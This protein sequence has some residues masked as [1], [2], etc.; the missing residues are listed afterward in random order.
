MSPMFT[1]QSSTFCHMCT[2]ELVASM[3]II[4]AA[5]CTFCFQYSRPRPQAGLSQ[6]CVRPVVSVCTVVITTVSSKLYILV[7]IAN[8]KYL[9]QRTVQPLMPMPNSQSCFWCLAKSGKKKSIPVLTRAC[10]WS[11]CTYKPSQNLHCKM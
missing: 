3:C 4:M 8:Q 1:Y 7:S 10:F 6:S 11:G 2:S 9:L 5:L